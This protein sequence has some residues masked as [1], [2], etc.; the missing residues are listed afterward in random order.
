MRIHR[1]ILICGISTFALVFITLAQQ[2]K[3]RP[4]L[5]EVTNKMSWQK[6]P[7]PDDMKAPAGSGGPH[8]AETCITQAQI[9]K[10]NGPKPEAHGGSCEITNIQKRAG[11]LTADMSCGPPMAGKGTF[12]TR[13]ISSGHSKSKIHFTG[14]MHVG[15]N[16]KTIEW[17]VDS[18]SVFK[19]SN[20]GNVKSSGAE[21]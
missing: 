17:T 15:E 1:N 9:D 2:P 3:P 5:Y 11:G 21:Q 16:L 6:S 10:Y 7:F 12:E 20:C 4:G 14:S 13:W 18:D 8:T 19:A